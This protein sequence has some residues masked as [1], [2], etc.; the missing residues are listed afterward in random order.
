MAAARE[1]LG[2]EGYACA[3]AEGRRL[4]LEQAVAEVLAMVDDVTDEASKQ[5]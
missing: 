3:F 1:V 5:D 4:P 2:E